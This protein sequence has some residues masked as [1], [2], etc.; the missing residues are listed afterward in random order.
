MDQKQ[1]TKIWNQVPE[2]YYEVEIANNPLKKFW[3]DQK[4][5]TFE[6]L[7]KEKDFKNILDVGCASGRMANE[8]SKIYPK[9]KITAIDV[10]KKTINYGK[11]T[12]PHIKFIQ[13]D[14]HKLPFNKNS[15][16]LVIN[17]EVIEHVVDPLTVLKE[18]RRVIKN[19]GTAIV[20]MDS[21]NWLFRIV[22]W[23]SE[24]TI[25]KVWQGAHLHPFKHTELEKVIKKAGFK[26]KRKYFSHFGMEV[27]F[28]LNPN[29]K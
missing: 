19:K 29:K 25:S 5:K 16:D 3:H 10:Y 11:K 8:I 7:V 12:Y 1:L 21:G 15:F 20:T 14:A 22:W 4:I 13:A 28:V 24:K 27:S 23:I 26:I 17:Y 18:I 9:A 2:N 6:K